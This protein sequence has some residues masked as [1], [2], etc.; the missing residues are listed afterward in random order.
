M[1]VL[2]LTEFR[3]YKADGRPIIFEDETYIHGSHTR[4]KN[5]TDDIDSGLLAPKSKGER[6]IIFHA[7]GRAGFISKALHIYKSRQKTGDYHNE[8]DS[9]FMPA[10]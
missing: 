2:Y 7:G 1:R 4:T 3:K 8:M 5:W 9:K 6:L 10:D